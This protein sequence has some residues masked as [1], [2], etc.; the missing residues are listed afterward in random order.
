MWLRL[1]VAQGQ[2]K[3]LMIRDL[4]L[5]F[6]VSALFIAPA[7]SNVTV[8]ITNVT[9]T[10]TNLGVNISG[11]GTIGPLDTDSGYTS[12][13]PDL[14]VYLDFSGTTGSMP[15]SFLALRWLNSD[16]GDYVGN[17][18]VTFIGERLTAPIEVSN[19]TDGTHA[20]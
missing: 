9:G 6:F 13:G 15:L 3:Q 5:A 1:H 17:T 11:G 18:Y 2:R 20:E 19:I 8:T 16:I 10:N 7:H 12:G 14:L 4:T